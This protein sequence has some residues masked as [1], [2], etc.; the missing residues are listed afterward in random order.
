MGF[1]RRQT[2]KNGKNMGILGH[3]KKTLKNI[4]WALDMNQV[5]WFFSGGLRHLNFGQ[6]R[7]FFLAQPFSTLVLIQTGVGYST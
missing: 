2:V 5:R 7:L 3:Y 1:F 4:D 6:I